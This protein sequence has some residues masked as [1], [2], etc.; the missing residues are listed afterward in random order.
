MLSGTTSVA[1]VPARAVEDEHGMGARRDGKGDL[2]EV[3]VHR[4]GVGEGHDEPRRHAARRADRA[5]DVGPLVAGVARRPRPGAA[6]RP[7]PG[8]RALLADPR[9]VLE[10]DLERLATGRLGQRRGYRLG[11]AFL[12]PP[13]PPDRSSDAAG[14]PR[15]AGSRAP[16]GTCPPSARGPPPRTAPR[17]GRAGPAA[18]SAPPRPPPGPARPPPTTRARPAPQASSRR[19]G[20]A[21]RPVREPGQPIGVVAVHP[22]PERLP[23]HPAGLRRSLPVDAFQH[24]RQ[25]QHPPRR[26][27]VPAPPRRRP[28]LRCRQLLP[29]DRNRRRHPCLLLPGRE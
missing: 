5:E 14:A 3:G 8:E 24:Q 20:A 1:A 26:L 12:K 27:R 6:L 22:V 11:E 19:G 7:D 17:S 13:G 15:A 28:Q 2:G 18:A 23:V 16:P 4:G 29:R 25:R 9:L 10:P 21:A